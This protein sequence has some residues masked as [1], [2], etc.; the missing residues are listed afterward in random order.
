MASDALERV[1]RIPSF[2]RSRRTSSR[3]T[4]RGHCVTADCHALHERGMG[5]PTGMLLPQLLDLRQ[6][7]CAHLFIVE[8]DHACLISRGKVV[9]KP[10]RT[11]TRGFRGLVVCETEG[12]GTRPA[13]RVRW[14]PPVRIGEAD[15]LRTTA[16]FSASHAF[17]HP[18]PSSPDGPDRLASGGECERMCSRTA[19]PIASRCTTMTTWPPVS[20]LIRRAPGMVAAANSALW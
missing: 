5:D 9:V 19:A 4:G 7:S 13:F 12:S 3:A 2:I 10:N 17:G 14:G 8:V 11:L 1:Q 15:A 6:S 18:H 16:P 20:K